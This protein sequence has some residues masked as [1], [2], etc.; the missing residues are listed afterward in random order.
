MA[1]L[2]FAPIGFWYIAHPDELLSRSRGVLIFN[3]PDY[4]ASRYPGFDTTQ[5]VLAQL[6]RG[7]EGLAYRGDGSNFFA[8]RGPILTR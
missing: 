7:L 8:L 4:L 1:V 5:I 3:Q 2:V 6:R